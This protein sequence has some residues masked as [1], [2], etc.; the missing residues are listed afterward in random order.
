[1]MGKRKAWL[2]LSVKLFSE[3]FSAGSDRGLLKGGREQGQNLLG[4]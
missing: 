3:E 2:V 1:M 4:W